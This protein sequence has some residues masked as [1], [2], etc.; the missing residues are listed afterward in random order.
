MSLEEI[1]NSRLVKLEKLR[2]AGIEPYPAKTERT[3]DMANALK[4]FDKL[5]ASG[6]A[7]VLAGR[8]RALRGHGGSTFVDLED[9]SGRMQIYFKKD[10]LGADVYNFI[11]DTVDVGD[12]IETSGTLFITKKN[13]KSLEAASWKM[14]AKTLLP[15]PEKWHG[16]QDMEER[17][18]RRY[19]DLI[20]NEE[21]RERFRKR[22]RV[23]TAIR[24]FF[25]KEGFLEVETPMLHSI[26]GGALANPFITHHNA[27]DIDLFLRIAPELYLKRLLVGG[28]D[29]VY[30]IGKNFRNEG[31]DVTHNPEFT[32]IEHYA[33]YWDEEHLLAFIERC[34]R[35]VFKTVEVGDSLVF[36]GKTISLKKSFARLPMTEALKRFAL[37]VDYAAETRDSLATRAR[38]LGVDVDATQSKGKIADEIFKK[39]CRPK[40]IDPTF[41]TN[42]PVDISPLAK[43]RAENAQEVRRLQLIMGGVEFTNGFAEL[44][45]PLDQRRRFEEQE[46]G[47]VKGDTELHAMD[48]DFVEALEYGMP[49]AAGNA[50]SIDR[51]T[52]LLTDTRNIR[53]VLLFPTMRPRD[54]KEKI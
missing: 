7:L 26:A 36:D 44:N 4:S 51:L 3:H 32:T 19:V 21:V 9:G 53:E 12:I 6:K 2:T 25:D 5:A 39:I 50:I 48:D 49:P 37:V 30:E 33:S 1:R 20:M 42:H 29:K 13:E 11:L 8:V 18:R 47:R 24:A 43:Q 45:D 28:F 16:L 22:S 40:I 35:F 27:L 46:A 52:M 23:V 17:F 34:I 38:Q 41:I 15:L 10:T 54:T 31:I 14:L